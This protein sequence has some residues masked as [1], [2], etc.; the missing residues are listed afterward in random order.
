MIRGMRPKPVM[1]SITEFADYLATHLSYVRCMRK[2]ARDDPFFAAWDKLMGE[3]WA[4][5][6][7][8]NCPSPEQRR[9]ALE[10]RHNVSDLMPRLQPALREL[11]VRCHSLHA[12]AVALPAPPAPGGGWEIRGDMLHP[13][14]V[15]KMLSAAIDDA[16][17]LQALAPDNPFF[18]GLMEQLVE[19]ARWTRTSLNPP[20][21]DRAKVQLGG[22]TIEALDEGLKSALTGVCQS[23]HDFCELYADFPVLPPRPKL[24]LGR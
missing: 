9:T 21:E 15:I 17:C 10:E 14:N 22:L 18:K 6:I 1:K 19:M 4:S 12:Y 23:L 3:R 13:D 8:G 5:V 20:A 24:N 16:R 11:L 7:N 2:L